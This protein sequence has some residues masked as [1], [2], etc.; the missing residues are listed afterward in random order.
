VRP[1]AG[2]PALGATWWGGWS[3]PFCG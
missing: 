2:V 3:R 1:D